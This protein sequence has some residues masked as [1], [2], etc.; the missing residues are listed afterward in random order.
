MLEIDINQLL[1]NILLRFHAL[2][3]L[4][5][6]L[7]TARRAATESVFKDIIKQMKSALLDKSLPVRR[8]AA[9]VR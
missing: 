9:D 2:V 3:A 7:E 6:A 4:R 1:Q 8:A 5:K